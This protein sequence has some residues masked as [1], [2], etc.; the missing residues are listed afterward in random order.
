MPMNWV[1]RNKYKLMVLIPGLYL[2]VDGLVHKG[3]VRVMLPVSFPLFQETSIRPTVKNK[4]DFDGKEWIKAV[5]TTASIKELPVSTPGF[6]CDVY[7]VRSGNYFDV[8][9]DKNTSQGI[10]LDSLLDIYQSRR[11]R[12]CIWLDLKNLRDSI[13]TEAC[14]ELMRLRNKYGLMNKLL[15]ESNHPEF[16]QPFSDSGV[17]TVYYTPYFNP[18]K[19]KDNVLRQHVD[20]VTSNI[21]KYP[22]NGLSGYYF[23]Y[24]YL[25][26]YFPNYPLL[27]WSS[28]DRFSFVNWLFRKT[29][30]AEKAVMIDLHP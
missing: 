19:V 25:H 5:N 14:T 10:R 27:I 22:I 24:P 16:L 18:Y 11:M 12:S 6:E 30:L 28:N 9:H 26:H 21:T 29:I 13:K 8:H 1:K 4:L 2:L 20:R 17:F 23:Q 15:V 3:M 7:F